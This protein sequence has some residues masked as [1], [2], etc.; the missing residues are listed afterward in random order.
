MKIFFRRYVTFYPEIGSYIYRGPIEASK[1]AFF[2]AF[3]FAGFFFRFLFSVIPV[4]S[5][6]LTTK[7]KSIIIYTY[8]KGS[9]VMRARELEEKQSFKKIKGSAF[10]FTAAVKRKRTAFFA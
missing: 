5:N 1:A 9:A 6:I 10:S 2:F 8:T 3:F 4:L 7:E